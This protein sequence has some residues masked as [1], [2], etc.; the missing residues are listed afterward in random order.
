MLIGAAQLPLRIGFPGRWKFIGTFIN[1]ARF[2]RYW[3][4]APLRWVRGKVHKFWMPCDLS[5]FSGRSAYFMRRWY[6]ADTQSVLLTLLRPGDVLVEIGATVGM[7]TLTGAR[8]V[9]PSGHVIAFEPNPQVATVLAESVRRNRLNNVTIRTAA[10]GRD[11]GRLP[12]FIPVSNHGEG[13]LGTDFGERT[14]RRIEVDVVG[15]ESLANLTSCTMIKIDVEGFEVRVVEGLQNLIRRFQPAIV[16]EVEHV[17]L[18]RCGSSI[19]EL[20]DHFA[21]LNYAGFGYHEAPFGTFKV[22][23]AVQ[24]VYAPGDLTSVNMLWVPAAEADRIAATNF[25]GLP[26]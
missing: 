3:D 15:P 17:H 6:E 12:F 1:N 9:G 24:R 18:Q 13:S 14:G 21:E 22:H 10:F 23:A 7:A 5:I 4:G 2:E 25:A 20:F 11:P 26:R 8:A 19:S 16:I